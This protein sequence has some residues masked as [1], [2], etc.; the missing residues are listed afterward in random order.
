MWQPLLSLSTVP[1]VI[2]HGRRSRRCAVRATPS[3]CWRIACWA[4]TWPAWRSWRWDCTSLRKTDWSRTQSLRQSQFCLSLN[5]SA[6][7][8]VKIGITQLNWKFFVLKDGHVYTFTKHWHLLQEID[9][10]VRKEIE[11]AAQFATTDPEPPL[12]D[13]CNHIF[14]NDLPMEVRGTN[15]WTKLKSIS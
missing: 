13:L 3:R 4:T 11:D 12:E 14:H 15:P 7:L 10:E 1:I 6:T 9:V 2:A 8:V 5:E